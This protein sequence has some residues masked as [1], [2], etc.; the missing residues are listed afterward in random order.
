MCVGRAAWS[1]QA[2]ITGRYTVTKQLATGGNKGAKNWYRPIELQINIHALEQL[3][4]VCSSQSSENACERW[5]SSDC[6]SWEYLQLWLLCVLELVRTQAWILKCWTQKRSFVLETMGTNSQKTTSFWLPQKEQKD[7]SKTHSRTC[8]FKHTEMHSRDS[9]FWLHKNIILFAYPNTGYL[10]KLK[11]YSHNL[12]N[13]FTCHLKATVLISA[14]AS[15]TPQ[16]SENLQLLSVLYAAVLPCF[17]DP[18]P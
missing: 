17:S 12:N 10:F 7:L 13:K 15:F 4:Q 3:T 14:T 5:N 2:H 16:M 11:L 9:N 1:T 18:L 8:V 6:P